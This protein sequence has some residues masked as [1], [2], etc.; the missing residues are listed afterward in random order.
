MAVVLHGAASGNVAADEA[1]RARFPVPS[2]RNGGR[3]VDIMTT[4]RIVESRRTG[5]CTS[6]FVVEVV[7]GH[8][9]SGDFFACGEK[10]GSF[11]YR[12]VSTEPHSSGVLLHCFNWILQD[13]QFVGE[14]V[15]T[16][17]KSAREIARYDR[18]MQKA[19]IL[20]APAHKSG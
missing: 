2:L 11:E 1:K 8:I 17:R 7:D 3:L 16:V 12:V 10:I 4:L 14:A 15:S 13:G 5:T 19:G 20:P 18:H 6:D 9:A